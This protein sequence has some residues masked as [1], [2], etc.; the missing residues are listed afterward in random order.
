VLLGGAQVLGVRLGE[1]G[2]GL[3]AGQAQQ[4]CL[5]RALLRGAAVVCLDEVTSVAE[6]AAAAALQAA[7]RAALA[8]TTVVQVAHALDA[9]LD[10]DAVAVM[11]GGRVVEAGPPGDLVRRAGSVLGGM[12]K[13]AGKAVAVGGSGGG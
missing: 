7:V 11:D 2:A 9:V 13:A 6:P 4:L 5:A 10:A 8:G 12:V 1:A 3:S